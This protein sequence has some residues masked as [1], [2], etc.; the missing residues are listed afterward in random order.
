MNELI[1]NKKLWEIVYDK[2]MES[3][4]GNVISHQELS[5]LLNEAGGT[6]KYNSAVE[7]AKKHLIPKGKYIESIRGKGYRVVL[8]DDYSKITVQSFAKGARQ[9]QKG[10]DIITYAPADRMSIPAQIQH[11]SI[12]DKANAIKAAFTESI[13]ELNLLP[14]K[15]PLL[16]RSE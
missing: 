10:Y 6:N 15:H 5:Y 16:P 11:R 14:K 8:P 12:L 9:I 13:V 2:I 4:Y 1:K 7:K 3:D